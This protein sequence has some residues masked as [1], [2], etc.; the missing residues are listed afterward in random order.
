[1]ERLIIASVFGSA[2][3]FAGGAAEAI[4]ITKTST[5]EASHFAGP[6][7]PQD[8]VTGSITLTFADAA[9]V[10]NNL[11][12]DAV[13][14]TIAGFTYTPADIHATVLLFPTEQSANFSGGTPT[15]P[16]PSPGYFADSFRLSI[17]DVLTTPTFGGFTYTSPLVNAPIP[18]VAASGPVTVAAVPESGTLA[19]L[20]AGL[21]GAG[22]MLRRRPAS[23]PGALPAVA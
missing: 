4:P 21:I 6:V 19:L 12:P 1:M 11:T 5:F 3:A 15:L 17:L 7:V 9:A 8:P 16:G 10:Q 2:L 22:L 23:L 14:L 20:G 18:I 13:S